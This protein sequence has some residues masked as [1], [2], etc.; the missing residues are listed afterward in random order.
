MTMDVL[1][2]NILFTPASL[3]ETGVCLLLY[4]DQIPCYINEDDDGLNDR[5]GLEEVGISL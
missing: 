5:L 2:T 3:I 1:R 4:Y